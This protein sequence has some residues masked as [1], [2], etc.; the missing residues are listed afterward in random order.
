MMLLV[1]AQRPNTITGRIIG[2]NKLRRAEK[3]ARD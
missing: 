1:G 2:R 3:L